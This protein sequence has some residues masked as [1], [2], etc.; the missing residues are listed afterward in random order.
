MF[1][2][3]QCESS[4]CSGK[5]LARLGLVSEI[6][7]KA[8]FRG[9]VLTPASSTYISPS[10]RPVVEDH[11]ICV[12]DCS[13]NRVDER[14]TTA[15]LK[16]TANHWARILPFLVAANTINYGRPFK[17]N[18]AE[19]F[20]AGLFITGF[21]EDA[22]KVLD[23]FNWGPSFFDLNEEYL[24]AYSNCSDSDEVKHVH[25]AFI[26]SIA[27]HHEEKEARKQEDKGSYLDASLL[28]PG[29]SDEYDYDSDASC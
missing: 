15:I 7:V 1:D 3:G 17:L 21:K 24:N 14:E 6:S 28:P 27:K 23:S 20:A 4:K 5:K 16:R 12:V 18:D 9:V 11:G 25:E 13:W 26:S 29:S 22:Y 10:D 2:T 19:A 8:R